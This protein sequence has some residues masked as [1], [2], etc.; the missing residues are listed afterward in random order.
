MATNEQICNDLLVPLICKLVELKNSLLRGEIINQDVLQLSMRLKHELMNSS[1]QS[2]LSKCISTSS[3]KQ[4][5][6]EDD[7]SDD[8]PVKEITRYNIENPEVEKVIQLSELYLFKF[9]SVHEFKVIKL[10][11][12]VE[13]L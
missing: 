11:E 10:N 4:Y 7:D 12:E 13:D 1:R 9:L 2:G 3:V 8:E 5:F 6:D